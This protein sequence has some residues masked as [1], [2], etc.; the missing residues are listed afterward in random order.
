ML[1][2]STVGLQPTKCIFSRDLP[3]PISSE[4]QSREH[5]STRYFF[6]YKLCD[7]ICSVVLPLNTVSNQLH[8]RVHNKHT[9]ARAT[10][11]PRIAGYLVRFLPVPVLANAR[12]TPNKSL[13]LVVASLYFSLAPFLFVFCRTVSFNLCVRAR[14]SCTRKSDAVDE[15]KFKDSPNKASNYMQNLPFTRSDLLLGKELGRLNDAIGKVH[16][17]N[18]NKIVLFLFGLCVF[19]REHFGR[20]VSEWLTAETL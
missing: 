4:S 14:P 18:I 11:C 15:Q 6:V 8:R 16:A 17:N 12:H 10:Q 3:L 9:H 5:A 13:V 2:L 20:T 7:Y 19:A 1:A